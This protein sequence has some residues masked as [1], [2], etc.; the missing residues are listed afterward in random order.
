MSRLKTLIFSISSSKDSRTLCVAKRFLRL[1]GVS[2]IKLDEASH[3]QDLN[4]LIDPSCL[5]RFDFCDCEGGCKNLFVH[6]TNDLTLTDIARDPSTSESKY[7]AICV[8]TVP[9]IFSE[10][11]CLKLCQKII[12]KD[13]TQGIYVCCLLADQ[14]NCVSIEYFDG[15]KWKAEGPEYIDISV[16]SKLTQADNPHFAYACQNAFSMLDD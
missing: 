7:G 13:E 14:E 9:A 2:T 12:S 1:V 15:R 6:C 11:V 10:A 16:V 4:G 3:T 5:Y 8:C